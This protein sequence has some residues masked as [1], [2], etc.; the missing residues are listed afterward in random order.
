VG[1]WRDFKNSI[2]IL[3]TLA[4]AKY[5]KGEKPIELSGLFF[6]FGLNSFMLDF[7]SDFV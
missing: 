3:H 5:L 4:I 2:A 6:N 1:I 7:L